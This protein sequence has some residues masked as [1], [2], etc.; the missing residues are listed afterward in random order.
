MFSPNVAHYIIV[1]HLYFVSLFRGDCS[2]N[3]VVYLYIA[4]ANTSHAAM[5]FF[6]RLF[7]FVNGMLRTL[8][9]E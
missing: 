7:E 9:I 8:K 5:I 1:K 2:R 3:L 4:F 6:K